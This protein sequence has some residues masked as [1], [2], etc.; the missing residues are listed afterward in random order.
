MSL[1]D[2]I[3]YKPVRQTYAIRIHSARF[4]VDEP[5]EPSSLYTIKEYIF[6]DRTPQLGE[7]KLFDTMLAKKIIYDFKEQQERQKTL[8]VHCSRGLNRAPAIAI[9]LNDIFQLGQDSEVL[10]QK[11]PETNW[12]IYD[13]MKE[14][15][16]SI[17]GKLP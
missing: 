2:A 14:V 3:D 7:G 12:Y 9:A 1:S 17:V 5:L 8:L 6:D 11:F 15:G 16:D 10:K 13:L 4:D